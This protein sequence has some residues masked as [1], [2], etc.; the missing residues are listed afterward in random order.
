MASKRKR[1]LQ[2]KAAR[3]VDPK[4]QARRD[5]FND[6]MWRFGP[7]FVALVII[8]SIVF[9]VFIYEPGNPKPEP[10]E[11]EETS[12]GKIYSSDDYYDTDQLILVEFFH[13]ECGHCNQQ[14]PIL[15]DIYDTYMDNSSEDYTSSFHMFSIGGYS[16]GS[17]EDSKSDISGFKFKYTLQWPHLY[18]PSGELMRDY[19]FGSYPSLVLV[20]NNEIVYSDSGTKTYEQLVQEIEKHL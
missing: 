4:M 13:S 6:M 12:T 18:D 20:K 17:K 7:P 15:R 14:A 19:E 1:K 10:W 5:S 11:L 9:V 2:Q 8:L 16:L 3:E